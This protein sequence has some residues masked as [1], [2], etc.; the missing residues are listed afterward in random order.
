VSPS[1]PSPFLAPCGISSPWPSRGPITRWRPSCTG[2]RPGHRLPAITP[3]R[4]APDRP[5]GR[6]R[7]S[8]YISRS[9][10]AACGLPHWLE[11]WRSTARA[12]IGQLVGP[13]SQSPRGDGQVSFA[14]AEKKPP[15]SREAEPAV[16]MGRAGKARFVVEQETVG[17]APPNGHVGTCGAGCAGHRRRNR[18]FLD[19]PAPAGRVFDDPRGRSRPEVLPVMRGCHWPDLAAGEA[20]RFPWPSQQRGM[21]FPKQQPPQACRFLGRVVDCSALC[22]CSTANESN[23]FIPA[24]S[25]ARAVITRGKP[26]KCAAFKAGRVLDRAEKKIPNHL[27]A[28]W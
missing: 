2:L 23:R 4:T 20:E 9:C 17:K 8:D 28:I 14:L 15:P 18:R 25:S 24:S 7:R 5:P 13:P 1:Q 27:E 10:C 12:K 22:R 21:F 26:A 11:I 3:S 19:G 6:T 16:V